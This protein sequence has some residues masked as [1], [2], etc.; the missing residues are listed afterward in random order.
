[1]TP[2]ARKTNEVF[3]NTDIKTDNGTDVVYLLGE[4]RRFKRSSELLQIETDQQLSAH[5][6]VAEP[7]VLCECTAHL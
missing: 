3:Y 4:S 5:I 6:T 7:L 1:M 2:N